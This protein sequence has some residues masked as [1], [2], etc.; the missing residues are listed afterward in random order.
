MTALEHACDGIV[1][2][3]PDGGDPGQVLDW[4]SG[5]HPYRDGSV[6]ARAL[7]AALADL[8]WHRL[9]RLS[10]FW[11]DERAILHDALTAVVGGAWQTGSPLALVC[12]ST[13]AGLVYQLG[14]QL[15]HANATARLVRACLP[16]ADLAEC[17]SDKGP[18]RFAAALWMSPNSGADETSSSSLDRL[19]SLV[20][21]DWC[22]EVLAVPAAR[23]RLTDRLAALGAASTELVRHRNRHVQLDPVT[24]STVDDPSVQD[25]LDALSLERERVRVM[26]A[27]GGACLVARISA[28]A[29]D[30]LG[31]AV[32]AMTGVAVGAGGRWQALQQLPDAA[33]GADVNLPVSLATI[34]EAGDILRP[35]S[36]DVFG[37][38]VRRWARFDEH[39]EAAHGWGAR[40]SLGHSDRGVEI[41]V[42]VEAFTTHVLVAGASGAGKSS[43][44]AHL[45]EQLTGL[46]VPW[47]VVEPVKDEYRSLDLPDV[48]VWR[49]G[50]P[51]PG[52]AWTLN[53]LEAPL[54]T[55]VISHLDR[56]VALLRGTFGLPDPLPYLLELALVRTYERAGWDLASDRRLGRDTNRPRW[57]TISDL[58]TVAVGLPDEL[59]YEAQVRGNLRAALLARLGGL[60][61]GPRGQLLNG[62]DP[63]PVKEVLAGRVVVNFDH[64]GD[65]HV[66]AFLMAV[67]V[68]RLAEERSSHPVARLAHVTVIEEAHRLLARRRSMAVDGSSDPQGYA[69]DT[70][71][72]LLAEVRASGEG[73]VIADQSVSALDRVAL[74]NT[75]MKIALRSQDRDDHAAVGAAMGLEPE[76]ERALSGLGRHEALVT[77]EGMDGPVRVLLASRRLAAQPGRADVTSRPLRLAS[78]S[79]A[80]R[81]ATAWLLRCE[82]QHRK[83][84]HRQLEAVLDCEQPG[85]SRETRAEVVDGLVTDALEDLGRRRSWTPDVVG[86]AAAA[87]FA[88]IDRPEHPRSLLLDGR[89][90]Y[91]ACA[92]VCPAGGCISGELLAQPAARVV[93][94]GQ[95]SLTRLVRDPEERRRRLARR[96]LDVLPL[97]AVPEA[98]Q[99][100]LGC[101]VVQVFDDW[102]DPDTVG[103]LVSETS[104][105]DVAR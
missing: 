4:S 68:L 99:H 5:E 93:A 7:E 50:A 54:D 42:P 16:G 22:L 34:S 25:I 41:A 101:L 28:R 29:I 20:G 46:N 3:I 51:D 100:A 73:V 31:A 97:D 105:P 72:N 85:L 62:S 95:A 52:P 24:S 96:V 19:S 64:I 71:A 75:G 48:V 21:I 32:G 6:S 102:A 40:V 1:S 65:D 77:W 60:V 15:S 8:R 12:V 91:L 57:P 17:S 47:M 67:I 84:A 11:G 69:A 26:L 59:G 43:H 38:P 49:P 10:N 78:P 35:P 45:L 9:N 70:I 14:A 37:L 74:V 76:Q 30:D 23:S 80:L 63:F 2:G 87:A 98:L 36:R 55:S 53:P 44:V 92:A 33:G 58:L 83:A 90:P 27:G 82:I 13:G 86:A 79:G 39:P 61:R 66:R 104:W 103:E 89:N 18:Y 81:R 94:E 56:V 88:G